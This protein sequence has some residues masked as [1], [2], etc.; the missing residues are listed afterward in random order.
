MIA[1]HAVGNGGI[2]VS[3]KSQRAHSQS[4]AQITV[5]NP[6]FFAAANNPERVYTADF[7]QD[8][9]IDFVVGHKNNQVNGK[10][11]IYLG[12]GL[13]V[14]ARPYQPT[15][16]NKGPVRDLG[17]GDF[18]EDGKPDIVFTQ[19]NGVYLLESY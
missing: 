18:N 16:V 6:I 10:I 4:V 14:F 9:H 2:D 15:T 3:T 1:S 17:V 7:D 8:T 12:N 5:A 11:E 19:N 13:G